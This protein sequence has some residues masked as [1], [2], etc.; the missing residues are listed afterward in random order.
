MVLDKN[1]T[2]LNGKLSEYAKSILQTY[3]FKTLTDT[4]EV[5]FYEDGVYKPKGE[6]IIKKECYQIIPECT[7]YDVSEVISY[8]QANTFVDRKLFN[9]DF[10][11]IV[12]ENGTLNLDTLELSPHDPNFLTTVKFPMLYDPDAKCPKFEEALNEWLSPEDKTTALELMGNVLTAN[13]KNF[14]K[15][16]ISIGEGSNGKS[17]W[18]KVLRGI[19]GKDNCSSI[20]IHALQWE[21]FTPAQLYGKLAN[22]FPDIS[23][24]ELNNLG[25][26]KMAVSGDAF[27]VEKKGKDHFH[28]E[29]FA[30]HFYSAN[31]M[32][33]M[34][35]NSDSI[36]RRMLILKWENQFLPGAGRIEDYDQVLLE[37]KAGIFNLMLTHYKNLLKNGKFTFDQSI[38]KVRETITRESDKLREFVETCLIPQIGSYLVKEDLHNKQ[39]EWFKFHGYEP[40]SI[41]KLSGRLPN[42]GLKEEIKFIDKTKR[43]WIGYTWNF[44]NDW[45][46][47]NIKRQEHLG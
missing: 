35:D 20:S 13:R 4:Q 31:E 24:R 43:V 29:S 39:V 37:E 41:R 36:Y 1:D 33:S 17:C 28:M 3:R 23:N 47:N 22:I 5:L 14:E 44:E 25:K 34:K 10:G 9:T 2:V 7:K 32:P 8:I 12:V 42:Y 40:Y 16:V 6:V 27:D 30:K 26:F 21:R 18:L 11:K 19:I 46:K 15:A 45:V 38:E